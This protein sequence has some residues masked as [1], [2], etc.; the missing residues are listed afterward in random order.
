LRPDAEHAPGLAGRDQRRLGQQEQQPHRPQHRHRCRRRGAARSRHRQ[1]LRHGPSPY[2]GPRLTLGTTH[3]EAARLPTGRLRR[4]RPGNSLAPPRPG[5][6]TAGMLDV[7]Q[8]AESDL[9]AARRLS[10]TA[11]G[12]RPSAD[13][14]PPAAAAPNTR[15][16]W[17][18][19][20]EHGALVAQAVDLVHEQ[21]WGG[22]IL[23]A[24]GVA[25]VAVAPEHRGRGASR[26]VMSTLLHHARDRGAAVAALFCTSSAVYRSLGFEVCGVLRTVT[27]PTAVLDR[28]SVPSSVR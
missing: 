10:G 28:R 5:C 4:L 26:A 25:S 20:D 22:R 6:E 12:W 2:G 1:W 21:W 24:S 8:L 13:A 11:F 16:R 27:L 7:R 9:P 17:G 15:V 19:F 3:G 23:A 18:A 14:P